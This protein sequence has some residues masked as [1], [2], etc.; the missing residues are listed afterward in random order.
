MSIVLIMFSTTLCVA[1]ER[2]DLLAAVPGYTT[3][4]VEGWAVRVSNALTAD[5]PEETERAME[6]LA[7][8][9]RIVCEVLPAGPLAKVRTVPIWMSPP[10]AGVRP[11]G[12]YHPG[13]GW[14]EK[15]GRR[16]ELHRCI[17]FTNTA[18]FDREIKR[19]P[20]LVLHELAHAYHDQVLGFDHALVKTAFERAR[21]S[22]SYEAV[23][24]HNGKT[25]KAYAITNEREYFAESTEA[26]F[27]RNDFFPF[28]RTELQQHD[29]PMV[30]VL[31]EV[32][33]VSHQR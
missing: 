27:G 23:L 9:L 7:E 32:W 1:D 28:N 4:E 17:E 12:E 8:Q 30:K 2:T 13:K 11:T 18:I 5:R 6:L 20:V 14:L 15:Q 21:N 3:H 33:E 31:S 22:G 24:R 29:A 26:F 25:E 19:M 16:P 10:Y